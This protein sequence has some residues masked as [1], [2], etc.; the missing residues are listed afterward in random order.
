MEFRFEIISEYREYNFRI[1]ER[2]F[3]LI[4]FFDI[5]GYKC[6]HPTLTMDNIGTPTQFLYCFQYTTCIENST[7]V[8]V[9]VFYS[10]FISYH[11]TVLEIII[12]INE[13]YLHA[14]GLD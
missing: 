7:F 1:S 12:I 10:V 13:I 9:R 8:I 11:L 2:R 14:G 5:E 3:V 6:T 4:S